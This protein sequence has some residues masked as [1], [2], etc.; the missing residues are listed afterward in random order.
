MYQFIEEPVPPKRGNRKYDEVV[1]NWPPGTSMVAENH[2]H[3]ES[4]RN[5]LQVRGYSAVVRRTNQGI[6]VWKL[7]RDVAQS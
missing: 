6:K 2:S 5:A 1:D 4:L 7:S 3:A